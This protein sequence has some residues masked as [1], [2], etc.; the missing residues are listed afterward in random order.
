LGGI[1]EQ[2]GKVLEDFSGGKVL[3]IVFW[4]QQFMDEYQLPALAK[5]GGG[6]FA[7]G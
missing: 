4:L 1:L 2:I 6:N 3:D 7:A 5:I